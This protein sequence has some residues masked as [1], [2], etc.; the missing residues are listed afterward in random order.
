IILDEVS[1]LTKTNLKK[2]SEIGTYYALQS[3]TGNEAEPFGGRDM[4]LTGDFHQFPPVGS[5]RSAL[6]CPNTPKDNQ[7]S[8]LGKEIFNS[9]DTVVLLHQQNR[10]QD[11]EW[12]DFMQ[13]LRTG[14]CTEGDIAEA[15]KLVLG[16]ADCPHTD[17]TCDPWKN[18]ILVTPRHSVRHA[19]NQ[20]S[21]DQHCRLTGQRRYRAPAVDTLRQRTGQAPIPMVAKLAI[22]GL[23]EKATGKLP[24]HIDLAI[25]MKVMV[26]LN[27]ATEKE[28]ANGT[29]GT[30]ENLILDPDEP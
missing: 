2:G 20:A 24:D 6:Y 28:I 11:P 29:R 16:H 15:R 23:N 19:W 17:F 27:L 26:V 22:A 25:G 30:I 4:V 18:A 10:I 14:D 1:M 5:N 7:D 12:N 9:F 21:L 13:R 8:V 3:Q